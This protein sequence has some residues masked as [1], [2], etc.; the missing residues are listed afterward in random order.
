M[1]HMKHSIKGAISV[2]LILIFVST[3]MLSAVLVDGGRY[4]MARVMAESALDSASESVLSYYNQMLYDLYGIFAVDPASVTEEQIAD[5]LKKY[6]DQTLGI[7]EIDYSGYATMLTDWLLEVDWTAEENYFKDYDFEVEIAAG[8][9]V[10]LA[11]TDYVEDQII[12]YMRYNAP[13]ELVAGEHSFL[14]KLQAIIDIKD[15][16]LASKE[17]VTI[18]ESHKNLFKNCEKLMEDLNEFNEKMIAFCCEPDENFIFR[19]QMA[20]T[21][22]TTKQSDGS[23]NQGNAVKLYDRFGRAFDEELEEIGARMIEIQEG[24]EEEGEEQTFEKIKEEQIQRYQEAIERLLDN[25][26]PIFY[27][28]DI[29]HQEANE[30]R[31]RVTMV[32]EEYNLY[33]AELQEK[34]DSDPN[35]EQYQTV[36]APEIALAK[37]NCGELLKNIDLL[38]G[39][40][41]FTSDIR[42][43]GEGNDWQQFRGVLEAICDNR[44]Y[45]DD[46]VISLKSAIEKGKNGGAGAYA[47][48]EYFDTLQGDLQA[49]MSQTSYFYKSHMQE[50][51]VINS[52]TKVNTEKKPD[53]Q[54]E[55]EPTAKNLSP[56]D[57]I[58][59]YTSASAIKEGN[60]FELK[61]NLGS[62]DAIWIM[63]AGLSFIDKLVDS[64]EG[65]RDNLYVNE[66]IMMTFPNVVDTK[67]AQ[68]EA[69]PLE[70]MR[71]QYSASEAEVE[72]ILSG[73]CNSAASELA[74]DGKILG[75]R[76]I[77]N[78]IAIFTDTAKR[79]QASAIAATISGPFAPLVTVVLLIAWAVAE[80]AYDVVQLKEGEAV[81][82]FKNGS[83]WGISIENAVKHCIEK[84]EDKVEK[85]VI[86]EASIIGQKLVMKKGE[87]IYE[88]YSSVSPNLD[89]VN[90]VLTGV[91]EFSDSMKDAL[92][93]APSAPVMQQLD[94][95]QTVLNPAFTQVQSTVDQWSG[96]DKD[97]LIKKINESVDLAFDKVEE[98]LDT[99][100]KD[101][102]KTMGKK[103]DAYWEKVK[104]KFP[105]GQVVHT[106]EPAK[107][108]LDYNDYLRILLIMMSQTT[109]IQRIQSLIQANMIYGTK[110]ASFR[111]ENCPVS[112]WAEMNC[113]IRYLF[114][115]NAILPDGVKQEGRMRFTVHSAR[116]Y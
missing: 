10:T 34:L 22:E 40:R 11:S 12:E 2:F 99:A 20:E 83:D 15:R 91:S 55:K 38:L 96:L 8:S 102:K 75:V 32:Y 54:K 52:D 29:L 70:K 53:T 80:S 3:Y 60:E 72:Y 30:L 68:E 114:M 95:L 110:N 36:Y 89:A 63:E 26:K 104:D 105:L 39:S 116:S 35:N 14:S 41:Q 112:I 88:A 69:A 84:A 97:K 93:E 106:G 71:K 86:N 85:A 42:K 74:V 51:D 113:S 50:T 16:L 59:N 76:T 28:A 43:L 48:A 23:Y 49:L 62:E 94:G 44:I 6:V 21:S 67:K 77:F 1:L 107:L 46:S 25:M 57:V 61:S 100:L 31:D 33:I 115:T 108:T 7:V 4:R 87:M 5:I 65:I 37:S 109:K 27:H 79:T 47:A 101:L 13:M 17:Q 19:S 103:W 24:E 9:S 92:K 73:L 18:T 81:V 64:L 111:M 45:G 90:T 56:G 58:V 82:L 66:Y 78:T 98:G